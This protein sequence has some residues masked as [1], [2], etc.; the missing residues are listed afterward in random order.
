[1]NARMTQAPVYYALAQVRF[2][3][4]AAMSKYAD[5]VQDLL[6]RDGYTLYEPLRVPELK[7]AIEGILPSPSVVM[8]ER[9]QFTKTDKRSGYILGSDFI[10]Y[11]TTEYMTHI[12]FIAELAKGLKA[13]HE[14]VNLEHLS[15]IGMRYLDAIVPREGEDLDE[16]L[17]AGLQGV[18]LASQAPR[19]VTIESIFDTSTSP[20]IQKGTL[21]V[22]IHRMTSQLGY[23]PDLQPGMLRTLER[24]V[25]DS[26]VKHAVIDTDHFVEGTMPL[27]FDKL[28]PQLKS[29]HATVRN[30]FD[31]TTTPY[32]R[33]LW[34]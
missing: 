11:H 33:S 28:T 10:S 14:V 12:E 27:D 20:M 18:V 1:M 31:S 3:P 9:W 26:A 17:A 6:R 19:N 2:N 15:R 22:R 13:V 16:Y 32:A 30:A 23:P 29:L 7:L 25:T 24:F 21:V 5:S 8:D 4:V 34:Q